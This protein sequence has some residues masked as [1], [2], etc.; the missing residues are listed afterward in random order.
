MNAEAVDHQFDT[1]VVVPV[2]FNE[3]SVAS[4]VENV[5]ATWVAAGRPAAELEFV[6]VDDHSGDGSW[7][8]LQSPRNQYPGQV[9]V[10]RLVRN[11]GSQLTVLAGA[12]LARGPRIATVAA[13]G[14][15]PAVLVA[16]MAAEADAGNM[17][18]LAV[19]QARADS[20]GTQAGAGFF[21]RLIRLLGL[22]NM[23]EQGFDAFLMER[24]LMQV[25]IEMRDPN[26]PLSVTIAWLGH[27]YATV[28]YD[29]LE[30][31]HGK[32]RWTLRKKIK[33][34]IDAITSVS[35]APIRSISLFGVV[36]AFLGFAYALVVVVNHLL[37]GA[38][39]R[40]WASILVAVL[41]IG[42]TQLVSL[43]VIGEYPWR[44]PEVARRRPL[45]RIAELRRLGESRGADLGARIPR[46]TAS[47]FPQESEPSH[48]LNRGDCLVARN[49]QVRDG[50]RSILA[51][52]AT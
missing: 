39:V 29:R 37:A 15:E 12:S 31:T 13:D 45:W 7:N 3:K 17:L 34:A 10:A 36:V 8:V 33:L 46:L 50:R 11:H 43:G 30:R 19:R 48:T 18:V 41:V 2:Y 6:L 38:P 44:T 35:Y 28:E 49:A 16:K 22:R 20:L 14:Q 32:S 25:I 52:I 51:Y 40:G 4:V 42:G 5:L 27:P 1:T 47:R 23:P 21:Y 24:E 26:I 9:T